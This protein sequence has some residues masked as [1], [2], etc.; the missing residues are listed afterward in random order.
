MSTILFRADRQRR[1]NI[2]NRDLAECV[3]LF[4]R[5][6]VVKDC[7]NGFPREAVGHNHLDFYA[8][9]KF[10]IRLRIRTGQSGMALKAADRRDDGATGNP[11]RSQPL[12]HRLR[13]KS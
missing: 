12:P 4:F 8:A 11:S 6:H 7:V 13:A 5:A 3:V 1:F 2:Q 10:V 9:D